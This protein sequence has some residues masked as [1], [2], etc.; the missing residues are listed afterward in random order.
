[1]MSGKSTAESYQDQTNR[2][3]EEQRQKL[4]QQKSQKP[5]THST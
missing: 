5:C 4:Q 2:P 3:T 1:L